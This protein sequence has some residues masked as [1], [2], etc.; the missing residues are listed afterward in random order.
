[1]AGMLAGVECARRRRFHRSGIDHFSG[2]IR[3]PSF[4]LY[5]SNH[6]GS[7]S[8]ATV[9][10]QRIIQSEAYDDDEKL[11]DS[12]REAKERLDER[13]GLQRKSFDSKR[14]RETETQLMNSSAPSNKDGAKSSRLGKLKAMKL[15]R[16]LSAQ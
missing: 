6:E 9:A 16:W 12:A 14:S 2:E 7:A 8:F 3:R 5:P 15:K 13:L 10:S 1:M 11:E 4:C